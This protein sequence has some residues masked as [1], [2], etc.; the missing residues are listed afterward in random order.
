MA[1]RNGRLAVL[2]GA[3]GFVLV[4]AG[5]APA[6]TPSPA[7]TFSKDIAPIF[8]AKCQECHQPNSIAP[9]SL[10]S[11]QE[12]RPWARAIKD[13]VARKQMPPWHIDQSVGVTRF[14]NDMSLSEAQI[15][16]IVAL[17]RRWRAAGRPE[18]PAGAQAAG[19]R[20]RMAGRAR[21]L[22]PARPRGPVDRVQD[23]GGRPGRLVPADAGPADHRAALGE[24][25]RDSSDQHEGPQD[26]APLDRLPG[27]ERRSGR[28]QHRHLERPVDAVVAR[29]PG[30][31]PPAADGM[32]DRQ[33]LR[34]VPRGHRQAD[35]ARAR[36]SRG[37]STCTPSAKRS[38][39]ARRSR[40]GST[41]RARSRRSAAT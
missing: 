30:E 9:M 24:D 5:A 20:Q 35:R 41:R 4:A 29:G 14:K 7:P 12:A 39:P 25:G 37:I 33:G 21:R 8:Q 11:Y 23:A 10:I 38:T 34:P 15:D 27:A 2:S 1:G 36:R 17:G 3:V 13:R 26:R 28:R 18:G 40:C 32:G 16:T 31:P 6:Q 22:R 19:H